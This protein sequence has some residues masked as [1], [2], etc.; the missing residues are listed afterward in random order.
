MSTPP[1]SACASRASLCLC[2][3][4]W[5]LLVLWKPD[6]SP[7]VRRGVRLSASRTGQGLWWLSHVN[8]HM[9]VW[10]SHT[11]A[12]APWTQMCP[13][14][15]FLLFRPWSLADHRFQPNCPQ[16]RCICPRLL[17]NY[18]FV[19]LRKLSASLNPLF[20]CVKIFLWTS[21]LKGKEACLSLNPLVTSALYWFP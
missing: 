7:S 21:S 4:C 10:R 12:V 17:V 5:S 16:Q 6:G 8:T 19:L 13:E 18:A 3:V 1:P 2:G 20:S 14:L 9:E 11:H 15:V